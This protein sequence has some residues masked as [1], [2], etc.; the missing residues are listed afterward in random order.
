MQP[1]KTISLLR[2]L[3]QENLNEVEN[4][5]EDESEDE[6]EGKKPLTLQS[7]SPGLSTDMHKK[8]KD[9]LPRASDALTGWFEA[10]PEYKD[11]A[12]N[13][14]IGAIQ[15]K[16]LPIF[17]KK[18]QKLNTLDKARAQAN[19]M[20]Q[21]NDTARDKASELQEPMLSLAKIIK[22]KMLGI[23]QSLEKSKGKI[24]DEDLKSIIP[25]V[26][27]SAMQTDEETNQE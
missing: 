23:T 4:E 21:K 2:Q 17:K 26:L 22:G 14:D 27:V 5:V 19:I 13:K 20:P 15:N 8:L 10:H 6:G 25:A 11:L 9:G 12:K 1:T 16:L 7:L 24:S 18:E 3:I